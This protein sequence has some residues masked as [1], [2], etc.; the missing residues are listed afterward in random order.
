MKNGEARLSLAQNGGDGRQLWYDP[1]PA[2]WFR[3]IHP[4]S[5]I[6]VESNNVL[7][8]SKQ[9]DSADFQL[10]EAFTPKIDK[11]EVVSS[12]SLLEPKRLLADDASKIA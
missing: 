3:V 4:V 10:L 11:I 5:Q 7:S 8:A 6:Q 2:D 1:I 9:T 12:D